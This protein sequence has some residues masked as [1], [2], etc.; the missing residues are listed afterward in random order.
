[1]C[2]DCLSSLDL[3]TYLYAAI[4]F[5]SAIFIHERQQIQ[6]YMCKC[7]GLYFTCVLTSK[8]GMPARVLVGIWI[9][10][11]ETIDHFHKRYSNT[12]IKSFKLCVGQ[13]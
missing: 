1:M 9:L 3:K 7:G 8:R 2:T 6:I 12:V 13:V 5:S 4:V 11:Q 10:I